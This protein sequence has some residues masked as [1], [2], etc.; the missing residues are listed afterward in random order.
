[1]MEINFFIADQKDDVRFISRIDSF[2]RNL[3]D[4]RF[5]RYL[6]QDLEQR[7]K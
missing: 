6:L 1:M 5:R 7:G 3:H 4:R 2:S